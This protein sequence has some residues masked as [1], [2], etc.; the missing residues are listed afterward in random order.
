MKDRDDGAE[1]ATNDE[2]TERK[3][4]KI[5]SKKKPKPKNTK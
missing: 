4:K 2:A 1:T 5:H 3:R